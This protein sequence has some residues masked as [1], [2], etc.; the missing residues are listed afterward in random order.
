M[1]A[2]LKH[3]YE[4]F[5]GGYATPTKYEVFWRLALNSYNINKTS[6][7]VMFEQTIHR[8]IFMQA[9]I[10]LHVHSTISDG[11]LTPAE[12]VQKASQIGLRAMALTD[13]DTVSGVAQAKE[14]A[15][16]RHIELISG[17]ELSTMYREK[18]IHVVGLLVDEADSAFTKKLQEFRKR[19]DDR[20]ETMLS[21]LQKEGFHIDM[22]SLYDAYPDTVIT[23]VHIA[24]FLAESGQ[25]KDIRAA[26]D[27]Y[28]GNDCRC[29]VPRVM[30]T[31]MDACEL[32][33]AAHGFPVLAHPILYHMNK[34][35]LCT[36][37]SEM[38]EIGP[39]GIEAF[40][41]TYMPGEEALIKKIASENDLLLSGGSDFHG[42]NKPMIQLGT[43]K[44][45]L[46]IPYS[47]LENLKQAHALSQSN[48]PS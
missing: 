48:I 41:S 37:I 1:F 2:F 31:P 30:M 15:T 38:K 16:L 17:V 46:A 3:I 29:Y 23:R 10:D 9:Q 19:R 27:K 28:I 33:Y 44:G 7:M 32:I 13:H 42:A 40:Y 39:L 24:R 45:R 36:L 47:V 18:E 6:Q 14:E 34:D 43:G 20:N 11:T 5:Y 22:Q 35:K 12:V 26:F 21:L 25:V 4:I 8:G